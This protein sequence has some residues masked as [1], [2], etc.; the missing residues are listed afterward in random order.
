MSTSVDVLAVV[1]AAAVGVAFG[2]FPAVR[3]SR[4]DPIEALR[5]E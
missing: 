1:F 3:A 5:V 4:L 2:M